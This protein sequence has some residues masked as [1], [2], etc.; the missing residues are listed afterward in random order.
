[1]YC[2]IELK[3]GVNQKGIEAFPVKIIVLTER[4]FSDIEIMECFVGETYMEKK[5]FIY[6]NLGGDLK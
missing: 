2:L 1:M 6:Q 4:V 3:R 5:L